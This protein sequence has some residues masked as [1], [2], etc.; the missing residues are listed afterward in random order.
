VDVGVSVM[1]DNSKGSF[2]SASSEISTKGTN[3]Q[4]VISCPLARRQEVQLQRPARNF[5]LDARRCQ[6]SLTGS[7]RV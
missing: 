4:A 2:P 5:V 3:A 6:G 7:L 1:W